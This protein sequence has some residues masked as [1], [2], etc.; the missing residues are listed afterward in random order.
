[1]KQK[2][3]EKLKRLE[4]ENIIRPVKMPTDWCALI[5]AVLKDNGK[6]RLCIDFTKP[7]KGVRRK[8]FTTFCRPTISWT[9]QSPSIQQ[10][11]LL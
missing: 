4:K 3:Q 2:L 5:V 11:G 1:M 10:T 6:V 8:N 9:R 7:S